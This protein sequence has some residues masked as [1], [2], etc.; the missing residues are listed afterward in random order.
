[1]HPSV[2]YLLRSFCE[3]VTSFLALTKSPRSV[4]DEILPISL[5]DLRIIGAK[6]T[7]KVE[8]NIYTQSKTLRWIEWESIQCQK[9]ARDAIKKQRGEKFLTILD[10]WSLR[11]TSDWGKGWIRSENVYIIIEPTKPTEPTEPTHPEPLLDI[12]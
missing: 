7:S 10:D 11:L 6:A 3:S 1:L 9:G 2:L 5:A 4:M 8:I 12:K